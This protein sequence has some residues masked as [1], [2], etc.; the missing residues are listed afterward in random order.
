M[1]FRDLMYVVDAGLHFHLTGLPWETTEEDVRDF[2]QRASVVP[3]VVRMAF[4][5]QWVFRPAVWEPLLTAGYPCVCTLVWQR[6]CIRSS[7]VTE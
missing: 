4:N 5:T 1:L 7:G 2:L 6:R 3:Q